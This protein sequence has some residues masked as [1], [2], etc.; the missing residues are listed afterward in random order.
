MHTKQKRN[1]DLSNIK[2]IRHKIKQHKLVS[3]QADK[4]K[5]VVILHRAKYQQKITFF[6]N[7]NNLLQLTQD[8]TKRFQKEPK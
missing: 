7:E 5:S 1:Q 3:T 8:Q 2:A 4:G 6:I